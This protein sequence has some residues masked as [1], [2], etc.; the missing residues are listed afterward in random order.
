M[1]DNII[2]TTNEYMIEQTDDRINI[3]SY[4]RTPDG[5]DFDKYLEWGG[6]IKAFINR[7]FDT[8]ESQDD[9]LEMVL[10]NRT[11]DI[12]EELEGLELDCIFLQDNYDTPAE[13]LEGFDV[14]DTEEEVI[15]LLA[16]YWKKYD[17]R[18]GGE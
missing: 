9:A 18:F 17:E 14:A 4:T 13:A 2:R 15:E 11:E 1:N 10:K 8:M 3:Y 5:T 12:K 16:D 7:L 6:P